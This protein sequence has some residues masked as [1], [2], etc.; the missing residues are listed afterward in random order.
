MQN[1]PSGALV[2]PQKIDSKRFSR[3][4]ATQ[5]FFM[6]IPICG[7]MNPIWLSY[8]SGGLK[9]PKKG[10]FL[11]HSTMTRQN[12]KRLGPLCDPRLWWGLGCCSG[13]FRWK[14]GKL[15]G[16]WNC[17]LLCAIYMSIHV[18]IYY[19]ANR[20]LNYTYIHYFNQHDSISSS[21][22]YI[23]GIL[24]LIVTSCSISDPTSRSRCWGVCQES[25][26]GFKLYTTSPPHM[27][28]VS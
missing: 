3:W 28:V 6:F 7:K 4:V 11:F 16:V 21:V 26:Q 23:F 5:I 9:P 24:S 1:S 17:E 13:K 25:F 20:I 2:V 18:F 27:T 22:L 19:L 14:W 15:L 10:F 8:F 12:T